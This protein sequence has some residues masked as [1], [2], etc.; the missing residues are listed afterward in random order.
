MDVLVEFVW[1]EGLKSLLGGAPWPS[2]DFS[3]S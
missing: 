1:Y 2:W 3:P